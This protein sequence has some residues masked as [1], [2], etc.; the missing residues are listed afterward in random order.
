MSEDEDIR[1]R[2]EKLLKQQQLSEDA[3]WYSNIANVIEELQ[4]H[5]IELELQNDELRHTQVELQAAQKKYENLYNYAPVGYVTFD[6]NGLIMEMNLTAARLFGA[7]RKQLVGR[8]MT[9]YLTSDSIVDFYQHCH[10]VLGTA[11]TSM[12]ITC[13]LTTSDPPAVLALESVSVFNDAG[14]PYQIHSAILDI[15]QQKLAE[16][17]LRVSEAN[18]AALVNNTADL[19]WAIDRDYTII[20]A[21]DALRS[22]VKEN[23]GYRLESGSDVFRII[24]TELDSTWRSLL[25]RAFYGKKMVMELDMWGDTFEVSAYPF[26]AEKGVVAGVVVY[27]HNISERK[28][29][30]NLLRDRNRQLDSFAHKIAHDLNSPLGM[31]AG[32]ADYISRHAAGVD[33][34]EL[35]R[36]GQKISD[37]AQHATRIVDELLFLADSSSD[38][39]TAVP[40][41]VLEVLRSVWGR[42]SAGASHN[43][44]EILWPETLP[45]ALGYVPWVEKVCL[46]LVSMVL[47]ATPA[48]QK[49]L[50]GAEK[51]PSG[52]LARFWIRAQAPAP[53]PGNATGFGQPTASSHGVELAV[54]EQVMQRMNGSTG[55]HVLPDGGLEVY[56]TLPAAQSSSIAL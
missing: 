35:Q 28:A 26:K 7:P 55:I 33:A 42:L 18:W 39:F 51:Q 19:I 4:I 9:P 2:A 44:V 41:D 52:G 16:T 50:V 5:Q 47:S 32:Y 6:P 56:F 15:T 40:L 14:V 38:K 8:T 17:R 10:T 43:H 3:A 36:L 46:N 1:T 21:N 54:I 30:E 24:P 53:G 20:R 13:E 25:G 48:P 34:E 31:L 12:P 49:L 11:D 37:A 45:L 22:V 23:M 27:A 29:M